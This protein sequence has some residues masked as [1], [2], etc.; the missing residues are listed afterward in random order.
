M[1]L[2]DRYT[3]NFIW[4]NENALVDHGLVIEQELPYVVSKRKYEEMSVLGSNR[5]LHEWFEDYEPYDFEIPNVSI[6]YEN[7]A[8]VKQWLLGESTLITH[9]DPDK[10]CHAI[11]NMSKE[12]PYQNEWGVFY[13]F[14]IVFRC[15]PLKYRVNEP[16][17]VLNRGENIVTN[18]G[19]DKS[20]PFFV[21]ES[22]GGD[23][24]LEC[25]E[26]KLT[27]LNTLKGTM[28]ID[29]ELAMCV[30]NNSQLRTKGRW[31][32]VK[33]GDQIIKVTGNITSGKIQMRGVYL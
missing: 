23:I 1:I 8:E 29:T 11:C 30:Q 32:R 19:D 5:I 12:Q 2:L 14:S 6:P 33:Q 28:T 22:G 4:K 18:H 13:T 16:E 21:F 17:I 10:Y 24:V 3:P 25:N 27:V 9:N 20:A 31:L 26:Y 7:L 15:D